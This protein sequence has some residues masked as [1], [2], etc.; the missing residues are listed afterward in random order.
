M[1]GGSQLK[2]TAHTERRSVNEPLWVRIVLILVAVLFLTGFLLLPLL[3]VFA[4]AFAQGV[5][6][7]LNTFKD[8]YVL[9]AIRL[10]LLVAVITVPLNVIFGV[11]AA[12]SI[13]KFDFPGKNILATLIDLPFA[14]SPVIAGLVF[15]LLFGH[16]GVL[17][18]W[19][20]AHNWKIVFAVPGII[21]ATVFVTFPFIARELI[22]LM[23]S[24]GIDEE[25][26]ALMLG[27]NGWQM[28]WRVTVP[29]I[30]WGLI[31]GVILCNSRAMGEFGAVSVVSGSI[32]GVTN[33]M[34]L[35]IQTRMENFD[36]AAFTMSTALAMLALITLLVKTIVELRSTQLLADAAE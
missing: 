22:P 28:F 14:V 21:L 17:G 15:L 25:Q 4:Q 32:Q 36:I 3:E 8:P 34:P 9:S 35:E 29:N 33:T 1:A 30:K 5:V 12:W 18:P 10:T 24:Q 19:L 27:A 11:A 2:L 26:A 13:S 23:Q 6:V 31:Y 16:Q 20:E 7:Y